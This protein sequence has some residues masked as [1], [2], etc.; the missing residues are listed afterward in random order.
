LQ[1]T[2]L[3]FAASV[4]SAAGCGRSSLDDDLVPLPT[5][6]PEAGNP[7]VVVSDVFVPDVVQRDV[8]N[9]GPAETAPPDSGGRC[10]AV[11]CPTGC[12]LGD[13][14]LPGTGNTACGSSGQACVSC[15]ASEAT[16]VASPSSTHI[17]LPNPPACTPQNCAGCCDP[18]G[19]CEAG[20]LD[21]ACGQFG[22]A[23]SDCTS[24]LLACDDNASPRACTTPQALCPAPYGGCAPGLQVFAQQT[25]QGVCSVN[26]LANAGEACSLGAHTQSCASFFS[27]ESSSSP[28]CAQCLSAFDFDYVELKGILACVAPFVDP[29]CNHNIAC[30]NDC[31]ASSC[32]ACSGAANNLACQ[33]QELASGGCS[34][35]ATNA[36]PCVATALLVNAGLCN[37]GLPVPSEAFGQWLAGVGSEF[38]GP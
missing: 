37:P 31:A 35:L 20:F 21:T 26:E 5:G 29:S 23:C 2:R 1:L 38:C 14:C 13:K 15:L 7:D 11:T 3:V 30:V 27:F 25:H 24:R 4:I 17:C 8:V 12:C 16:C 28:A 22:V 34:G 9:D 32:M 6:V 19:I 36:A 10:N 33:T 18:S